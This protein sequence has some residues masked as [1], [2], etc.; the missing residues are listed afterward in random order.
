MVDLQRK[1]LKVHVDF[2]EDINQTITQQ[3]LEQNNVKI[4]IQIV[5]PE[6][7]LMRD[8]RSNDSTFKQISFENLAST[9]KKLV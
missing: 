8:R 3:F 7:I 2:G 4:V 5:D 1:D 6:K 9:L